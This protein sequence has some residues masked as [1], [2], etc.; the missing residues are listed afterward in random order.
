MAAESN[1]M[2][3]LQTKLHI[4]WQADGKTE[5]DADRSLAQ[6]SF[7]VNVWRPGDPC[8][9]NQIYVLFDGREASRPVGSFIA[10]KN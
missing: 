6:D 1:K 2:L 3:S 7:T 8:S 10:R 5:R 4:W 9:W